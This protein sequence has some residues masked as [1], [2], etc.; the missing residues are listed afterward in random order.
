MLRDACT[1]IPF[2]DLDHR[3]AGITVIIIAVIVVKHVGLVLKTVG[4]VLKP[5]RPFLVKMLH[6]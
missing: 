4:L 3:R 1:C 2:P 5:Y 6:I